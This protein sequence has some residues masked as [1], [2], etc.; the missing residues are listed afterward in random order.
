MGI[1]LDQLHS[2][3]FAKIS[4]DIATRETAILDY[5]D[6]RVSEIDVIFGLPETTHVE[7]DV[8]VNKRN[9]EKSG[10]IEINRKFTPFRTGTQA[11]T[12]VWVSNLTT[13][14]SPFEPRTIDGQKRGISVGGH[15]LNYTSGNIGQNIDR[16]MNLPIAPNLPVFFPEENDLE[17][18]FNPSKSV[19]NKKIVLD[20]AI[21]ITIVNR[22]SDEHK[23]GL[24]KVSDG[25]TI[26]YYYMDEDSNVFYLDNNGRSYPQGSPT[27]L[28][29]EPYKRYTKSFGLVFP[30]ERIYDS[31]AVSKYVDL[32]TNKIYEIKTPVGVGAVKVPLKFAN[33]AVY[34]ENMTVERTTVVDGVNY[35]ETITQ[36]MLVNF[37]IQSV[38][39]NGMETQQLIKTLVNEAGFVTK[40]AT[41][42]GTSY[43]YL[44]D[45][46]IKMFTEVQEIY[47]YH[48]YLKQVRDANGEPVLDNN[49][50]PVVEIDEDFRIY[51]PVGSAKPTTTDAQG[52]VVVMCPNNLGS[53]D[54]YSPVKTST[55]TSLAYYRIDTLMDGDAS[56]D[57][58]VLDENGKKAIPAQVPNVNRP[59][60]IT[61][62]NTLTTL[63]AG[64]TVTLSAGKEFYYHHKVGTKY[65]RKNNGDIYYLSNNGTL[66]TPAQDVQEIFSG[67]IYNDDTKT[68]ATSMFYT[69]NTLMFF[70]DEENLRTYVQDEMYQQIQD[71]D[72][73]GN[74]IFKKADNTLVYVSS[75]KM[76]TINAQGVETVVTVS[77]SDMVPVF[78]IVDVKEDILNLVIP[79]PFNCAQGNVVLHRN[80]VALFKYSEYNVEATLRL[81]KELEFNEDINKGDTLYVKRNG[82][83][84]I[85]LRMEKKGSGET[86]KDAQGNVIKVNGQVQ[87]VAGADPEGHWTNN[88]GNIVM[89]EFLTGNTFQY[90]EGE[91]LTPGKQ[92][93]YNDVVKLNN[94]RYYQYTGTAISY[95]NMGPN[96][97]I[98][99]TLPSVF[100]E[101]VTAQELEYDRKGNNFTIFNAQENDIIRFT[102]IRRVW[103]QHPITGEME[104]ITK[105]PYAVERTA[106]NNGVNLFVITDAN[107]NVD[108]NPQIESYI[109]Y[110][111][112]IKFYRTYTN[113]RAN[114]FV[115]TL[116]A[117]QTV[118]LN[119]NPAMIYSEDY[120]LSNF[121]LH[122]TTAEMTDTMVLKRI[123]APQAELK[124][125]FNTTVAA[126]KITVPFEII[127]NQ[128]DIVVPQRL[129]GHEYQWIMG[130]GL[131]ESK[132]LSKNDVIIDKVNMK[133][134]KFIGNTRGVTVVEN[135]VNVFKPTKRE[136]LLRQTEDIQK[137]I[138]RQYNKLPLN[139]NP[140]EYWDS[141]D[142][143]WGATAKKLSDAALVPLTYFVPNAQGK[144][145]LNTGDIRVVEYLNL[146]KAN[147]IE[148]A[149]H[150]LNDAAIDAF[151]VTAIMTEPVKTEIKR[152]L[153]TNL[154]Q[155]VLKTPKLNSEGE[156]VLDEEG[157]IVYLY[158]YTRNFR[159][160]TRYNATTKKNEFITR[161]INGTETVITGVWED[162]TAPKVG[163]YRFGKTFTILSTKKKDQ[164]VVR[165]LESGAEVFT[166]KR[167]VSGGGEIVFAIDFNIEEDNGT[168]IPFEVIYEEI[169]WTE[170]VDYIQEGQKVTLTMINTVGQNV[171]IRR[172]DEF[173]MIDIVVLE[174]K[175]LVFIETWH[176]V[177]SETGFIF[178]FGNVQYQ[179][180]SSDGV[181]TVVFDHEFYDTVAGQTTKITDGATKYCQA[182]QKGNTVYNYYAGTVFDQVN[183]TDKKYVDKTFVEDKTIGRGWK[184]SGLNE[185]ERTKIFH[186]ADHNL[187]YDG[188]NLIQVR[189]RTRCVALNL[190]NNFFKGTSDYMSEG[191]KFQ[192]KSPITSRIVTR[193]IGEWTTAED[194]EKA[195]SPK[196]ETIQI[197]AGG[198]LIISTSPNSLL[199]KQ[200][201]LFDDALFTVEEPT[202]LSHNGVVNA[203]P[204]ALV[205]RR[206]QGV[207]HPD[208]NTNGTGFFIN[209]IFVSEDKEDFADDITGFS[210]VDEKGAT[211]QTSSV[212]RDRKAKF[213]VMLNWLF[214]TDYKAGGSMVSKTTYRP[215]GLLYD[216]ISTRD[217]FDLRI[218]A[219]DQ[220]KR[221][222]NLESGLATTNKN[223]SDFS[224]ETGIK[225]EQTNNYIN[226]TANL[227]Y[228]HIAKTES[229]IRKDMTE[230]D[231]ALTLGLETTNTH[232][233]DLSANVFTKDVSTAI[234]ID[235]ILGLTDYNTTAAFVAGVRP[236]R[237]EITGMVEAFVENMEGSYTQVEFMK[238][239]TTV[240]KLVTN[241]TMLS[242]EDINKWIRRLSVKN[243]G[244]DPTQ[245]KMAAIYSRAETLELIYEG[246]MLASASR[247][248][249]PAGSDA[250][251][252]WSWKGTRYNGFLGSKNLD[253]RMDFLENGRVPVATKTIKT[254]DFKQT[255]TDVQGNVWNSGNIAGP[256]VWGNVHAYH[257][258][259]TTWIFVNTPFKIEN[260]RLNGDDSHALFINRELM[261]RN[262]Y[263]C[264]DTAYTFDFAVPGWYRIDLVYSE[265]QG[266]HYVQLGWN[267]SDYVSK[268]KY[269]TTKNM[270]D[271]VEITKLR[272]DNW[273]SKQKTLVAT[274]KGDA[275]DYFTKLEAK[276]I[277]IEGLLRIR[278]HILTKGT[279]VTEDDLNKFHTVGDVNF[280]GLESWMENVNGDGKFTSLGYEVQP[281][282][283]PS[284]ADY[285][286]SDEFRPI[287]NTAGKYN[288]AEVIE[289]IRKGLQLVNGIDSLNSNDV[290][291]WV[292]RLN[293]SITMTTPLYYTIAQVDALLKNG[294]N[295][296]A[297]MD[298]VTSFEISS[299]LDNHILTKGS[300]FTDWNGVDLAQPTDTNAYTKV[301]LRTTIIN[302]FKEILGAESAKTVN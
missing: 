55:T 113:N 192:G 140:G 130:D 165:L 122:I 225:F 282:K 275:S 170:G 289:I 189:Y 277:L 258:I 175:D 194:R 127:K 72:V 228:T 243:L 154:D 279:N 183:E 206:N 31:N 48:P 169:N 298:T 97:A 163:Y 180:T 226:T 144:M 43:N 188:E 89:P 296:L 147:M 119:D 168:E 13:N 153:N 272:L 133:F 220:R 213:K 301:N 108:D 114:N 110:I 14:E 91:L 59:V 66:Y 261:G 71:T 158:S 44:E 299:W 33:K 212:G 181:N 47:Y 61:A 99:V 115:L 202:D 207:Y 57:P 230:K 131:P 269:M 9:L 209:G 22:I 118:A 246:L 67:T 58:I 196:T 145:I 239:L 107:F 224:K 263:C 21:T 292:T 172:N 159:V 36:P 93:G 270:D 248:L 184:L 290:E 116:T 23:I 284:G 96:K 190:F 262:K 294:A 11:G 101:D 128:F 149:T 278:N 218:D 291:K 6:T 143:L 32:D 112:N 174:R 100:W 30:F 176:E 105:K 5:L 1:R 106:L 10:F 41:I 12:G 25:G 82:K 276:L 293:I 2:E 222:E 123:Q 98:V 166:S 35:V 68:T 185:V 111:E 150:V 120:F 142:G 260:A 187:Y 227:I 88:T 208:F 54:F 251:T 167:V 216:E 249:P 274:I 182:Y 234:L 83:K 223:L 254:T 103:E 79:V 78:E 75:T 34:L 27:N 283:T 203:I 177:V 135:G 162:I 164:I 200:G 132:Y 160:E 219:N 235:T 229:A 241:K 45:N 28:L 87:Y 69:A 247:V 273:G 134:Y 242:A 137:E 257:A 38:S 126:Q 268:I 267:P 39:Q 215:D 161:A 24:S 125:D 264:R 186:N 65:Y 4:S 138:L 94:G 157:N 233:A 217:I 62:K 29:V 285:V 286:R 63:T 256:I 117:I 52:V 50:V 51:L 3:I 245:E 179:G 8:E 237:E 141:F 281:G 221:I 15:I 302:K 7:R 253:L 171:I 231:T 210:L 64:I 26:K 37:S 197:F 53:G 60:R 214:S 236:S 80:G 92:L 238:F 252:N 265:N 255:F 102:V 49:G 198:N 297:G 84:N 288:K 109:M 46:E 136:S 151:E 104:V 191:L 266:G 16:M 199:Y 240:I 81:S 259:Y 17:M 300:V 271:A 121:I 295:Y 139:L 173:N 74:R 146:A 204:I 211:L 85:I 73:N 86:Q 201:K 155:F 250:L 156:A 18:V 90:T 40:S 232:L 70:F 148:A 19:I 76:I 193:E 95:E 280:A 244:M 124:I 287:V 56:S 129:A 195:G 42:D 152:V 20:E 77:Y 178:P 205:S